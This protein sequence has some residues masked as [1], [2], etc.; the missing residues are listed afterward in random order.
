MDTSIIEC[1]RFTPSEH[2]ALIG[3]ADFYLPATGLEIYGCKFF[4]KEGRSWIKL[5]DKETDEKKYIPMARFREK[6]RDEQFQKYAKLAIK[7]FCMI[8][9]IAIPGYS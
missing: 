6:K 9:S 2:G 8:H 1:I 3:F 5:P 7:D 4:Q